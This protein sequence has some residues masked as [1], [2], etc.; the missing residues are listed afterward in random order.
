MLATLGR[1]RA[2]ALSNWEQWRLAR[3]S[4][5]AADMLRKR[6]TYLGNAKL[7]RLVQAQERTRHMSGDVCEFGVA[8]GGSGII[9]ARGKGEAQRFFGFDVF[10]MIPPP[11]SDKDDDKSKQRY[12]VIA[13]GQSEGLGGDLYYGYRGDLYDHVS[14]AFRQHGIPADGTRVKLIKGLFEDTLPQSGIGAIALAHIDCDWFDPVKLC[15]EFCAARMVTG[16]VIVIDDYNDYGGCRRAVDEF[17]EANTDW[18]FEPGANPF[19]VKR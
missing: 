1:I 3:L 2:R 18:S 14:D 5:L 4:P 17:R 19:L 12:A 10:A 13:S 16:G 15:L 6:L 7:I 8:L 11:A 9:L